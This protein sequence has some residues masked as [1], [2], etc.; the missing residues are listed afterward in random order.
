MKTTIWIHFVFIVS[1]TG[2][3]FFTADFAAA[4]D[5]TPEGRF[6]L[7]DLTTGADFD[8]AGAGL[9]AAF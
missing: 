1:P 3:D 6:M 5:A 9:G 8:A 7:L 2:V 4:P